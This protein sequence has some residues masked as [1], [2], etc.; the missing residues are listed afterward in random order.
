MV[1]SLCLMASHGYPTGLVLHPQLGLA[2]T[3]MKGYQISFPSPVAKV[4][5]IR[6]ESPYLKQS[7]CGESRK[8]QNEWVDYN[9]VINVD[10]SVQRPVLTDEKANCSSA[11]LFGFGIVAQ[12]TKRDNIINLLMSET[13][14]AGKDGANLSLLSKLMKLQLSGNGESRQP[15]SSLIYPSNQLIIQKP[16]LHFVQA[17]ALSSK[18]TVHPDGQITF[19]GTAIEL[20]DLVSVVAE[21]Y[22]SKS[23]QKGEKQFILVPLFNWVSINE[24]ERSHPS[25]L[26]KQS[27]LTAPLKSPEKVKPKPS[28]RKSKKVGMDRDRYRNYSYACETLLTL[29]V[30]KKQR[31]RTAIL[32]LKK[33]SSELFDLLI[34]F[35]A[36]IGGTGVAFLLFVVRN[37]VGGKATFCASN[38]FNT[39][40]GLGLLCLSGAV[41]K[42]R[43]T[44][45][46][47]GESSGEFGLKEEKMMQKLDESIRDIYYTA[48]AL[49]AVV[50]LSFA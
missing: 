14:E 35:T 43:V 21:S 42:L 3:N 9:E 15:L 37:L 40:F 5:L 18:I 11:V 50:M 29:I 8:F 30:D 44:I 34:Q 16:L 24:L 33:F 12:C 2:G 39:G 48:A 27:T 4:D 49:L 47:I 36:S 17:S 45:S 26:K 7:P 19:M 25:T 22:L 38:F 32:S 13:A 20:K 23:S 1:Q 28:P 10:F 6:Y 46:S 31:G 41:N